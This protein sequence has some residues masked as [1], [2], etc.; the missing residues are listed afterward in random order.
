MKIAVKILPRREVLDTQGRAVEQALNSQNHSITSC[1]VGK[2]VEVV[3]NE[4]DREMALNKVRE[5]AE[6]LLHNPLTETF[7]LEVV[8]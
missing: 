2:Y 5:M 4:A 7:Q 1:R 6:Q 8:D 3:L